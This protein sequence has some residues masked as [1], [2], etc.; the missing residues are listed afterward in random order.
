MCK[1]SW[2]RHGPLNLAHIFLNLAHQ[3][4]LHTLTKSAPYKGGSTI[5]YFKVALEYKR[6]IPHWATIQ[7]AFCKLC[8]IYATW[9]RSEIFVASHLSFWFC[10]VPF[11]NLTLS[12][13]QLADFMMHDFPPLTFRYNSKLFM[14]AAEMAAQLGRER[15]PNSEKMYLM[16]PTA[17]I[18]C[19][20]QICAWNEFSPFWEQV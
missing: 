11:L 20:D 19:P 18:F 6:K 10:L 12:S 14:W 8:D 4:V 16:A 7:S 17:K 1:S 13:L 15:I 9:L 3:W 5:C 2:H